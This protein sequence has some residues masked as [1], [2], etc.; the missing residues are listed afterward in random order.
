LLFSYGG[1]IAKVLLKRMAG[2][3]PHHGS[4]VVTAGF[5]GE[6]LVTLT[7][8]PWEL[9]QFLPFALRVTKL[10]ARIH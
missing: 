3:S 2:V 6:P 4:H 7:G 9:E 5:R 10:L 1:H 8:E